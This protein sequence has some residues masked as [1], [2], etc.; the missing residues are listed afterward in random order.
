[1]LFALIY[2]NQIK[3]NNRID[4]ILAGSQIQFY[5]WNHLTDTLDLNTRA[6]IIDSCKHKYCNDLNVKEMRINR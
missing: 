2:L 3:S 6:Q 1:M 5:L 4:S